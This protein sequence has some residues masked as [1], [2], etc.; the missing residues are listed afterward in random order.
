MKIKTLILSCAAS[1]SV[2]TACTDFDAINKDPD[3]LETVNPG[4]ML[5][6]VLYDMGIYNWQRYNSFT[7]ELMQYSSSSSSG[8]YSRYYFTES[9]GTGVWSNYYT[10]LSNIREIKK[11]AIAYNVPNYQAI[12]LT[13]EGWVMQMLADTFGDVPY[14]EAC[15]AE[16]GITKPKFNSQED[17]YAGIIEGLKQANDLYDEST[18]LT[19]NT[20]GELLYGSNVTKWHKF[21]NSILLRVLLRAGRTDEL[22][23]V[24]ENP[25]M[26]PV[27]ESNEDAALLA[28]S[29]TYPQEGP[30]TRLQDFYI[31]RSATKFF[32]DNLN[33]WGDPR[34]E[35]FTT[36]NDEGIY[37]GVPSGYETAPDYSVSGL[38][39]A[40]ATAPMKINLMSYAEVEFIR[41]EAAQRGIISSS[42]AAEAYHNGVQAAIE[43]WDLEVPAG[44]FDNPDV[45]YDGTLERIMLQKYYSLFFCDQQQWFE[46]M[47]TGLP[48]IPRGDGVPDGYEMP[49]RLIYP[50]SLQRS[51]MTG[52]QAA[53]EHMGG[54][55]YDIRLFWQKEN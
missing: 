4:T 15:R 2:L 48:A 19:Y 43:Q 29:G 55:D 35:L 20:S 24:L 7:G 11:Q 34:V 47:R 23:T 51:N 50:T 28:I 21:C 30:V 5:D 26:Y 39:V 22:K 36:V 12:A 53:V 40:I 38:N 46:Y 45:A 37:I 8:G 3:K 13:L 42:E 54:D 25:D 1:I 6:P 41:A 52:Y 31:A 14:S 32:I 27:F 16:E 18:T 9:A 17:I 44:Y 10:C 49:H 33:A